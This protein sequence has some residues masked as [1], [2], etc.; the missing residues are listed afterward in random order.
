MRLSC[1]RELSQRLCAGALLL[2][3]CLLSL[4]NVSPMEAAINT[5]VSQFK[6]FAGKEGSN[7]TLSKNELQSLLTS[8]LPNYTKNASDSSVVDQLMSSVD[9]N[10]DG[11]LSFLEFWQFIGQLASTHGGR[12]KQHYET[13]AYRISKMES[14]IKTVVGQFVSSA[15][16]KE[17]LNKDNFQKLVQ[18]QLGNIMA[19]TD[20][21]SA[22]KDMMRGLD[23]NQDGKVSFQEY[24][25]LIGYLANSLSES[26]TKTQTATN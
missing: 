19:D 10:N 18:R 4:S 16:G 25:T 26:K 21:S 11:E 22:V 13:S 7:H 9:K 3:P 23:E 15:R 12:E 24:M 17:S 8:Q 2:T 6:A 14:A 5:L 20:S 1:P